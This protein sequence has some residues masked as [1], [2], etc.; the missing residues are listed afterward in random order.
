MTTVLWNSFTIGDIRLDHRLAMAPMTR[1][2]STPKGVPTQMNATYYAQ[3]ASMAL[4]ISEGTQPSADG[5][6]YPL[7]PGIYSP[8][9]IAGW[10]LVTDAVHE[11]GGRIIIQLMHVGRIS[12]PLNTPHGRQP[13]APSAAKAVGTMFTSVAPLSFPEPR[14]LSREEIAQTVRDHRRA[15][16]AAIAAG[17]DGVEIHAANGYLVHQFL[18][19]N[20]NQ[21]TDEYGGSIENR[22]RFAVEV[23]SGVAEEIGAQRTGIVISPGNPFNDIVEE[24]VDELY[25]ALVRAL[26]PLGLAYLNVVHCGDENLVRA[27]RSDWPTALLL[28]RRGADIEAR[29]KDLD[30]GL[31]DVITVGTQTLANPDLVA[32]L[33]VGAPLNEVDQTTFYGG[34]ERGYVDYPT[35]DSVAQSG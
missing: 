27:I 20:V 22:I 32:R 13:V 1:G 4:I 12:H 9:Q 18:S 2:R 5:Q 21:R 29:V 35:L 3:R 10:R 24:D 33:R 11:A 7:T 31:A 25:G 19:S 23:A 17:A 28:N 34:G 30:D 15:A 8:Q 6:G 26:S 16:A 14:A